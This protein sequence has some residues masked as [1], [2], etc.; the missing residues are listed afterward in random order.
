MECR[1]GRDQGDLQSTFDWNRSELCESESGESFRFMRED[2]DGVGVDTVRS[3]R[4][5][6]SRA[7]KR[8]HFHDTN[9]DANVRRTRKSRQRDDTESPVATDDG[10]ELGTDEGLRVEGKARLCA[11][12]GFVNPKTWT[13]EYCTFCMHPLNEFQEHCAW[14]KRYNADFKGGGQSLTVG[15]GSSNLPKAPVDAHCDKPV[16]LGPADMDNFD[17]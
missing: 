10:N 14:R 12:C 11:C 6:A 4:I 15:R 13:Q 17:T 2:S 8:S 1:A 5:H 9:V 7:R 16:K 3:R